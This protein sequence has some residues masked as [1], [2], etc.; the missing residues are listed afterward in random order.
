MSEEQQEEGSSRC[1]GRVEV[2][3]EG[4]WGTVCDD[5][6]D[7]KE[8]QVVCQQ[9]G[10]GA[11]V[12]T[13][14]EAYF[15]PGSGYILLDDVQCSG[16]EVSLGQCSHA[17][18]FVHNCGHE[19]DI[20]V[21]C[22]E[23]E[24]ILLENETSRDADWPQLQFTNGSGRCSGRVEVYYRGQWGR[25]CDDKWDLRE[26]DVVC[27]QLNCGRA[28]EAPVQSQFGD[29]PGEFLLDEMDCTG[30]ESFLGQCPHAGWHLHNCG[31]GEDASV[32]CEGHGE[33]PVA[34]PQ[35]D[36]NP[37]TIL[38]VPLHQFYLWLTQHLA[39]EEHKGPGSTSMS[40]DR[41]PD[42]APVIDPES[43][44]PSEKGG[45]VPVRLAGNHG[46][47]AGRVELFYQGVWGTVCDDLWD[48]PEANIICRQLGCGWA[49]SA[50]S[51]AYFGQGSGKILLDNVHCKGHEEHLEECSHLGWFSHNCDHS[52]DASVICS[53]AEYGTATLS[54]SP[55]AVMKGAME[56]EKSRCGGVITSAPGK[57]KNPPMNEM[58]D[59][60]TCVWE[61]RAST[62]ERI[63]LAFPSLDLDCTNEYFEIL[64]G[65]PSSMKSLGKP[66]RGLHVTFASHSSSMTLVYFRGENNI[67]KNFVAYYYF[68]AEEMT[69]KTPYLIIPLEAAEEEAI[70]TATSKMVTERPRNWPELQL[71]GGSNRCSGRVEILYQGVWG[72][73]CDDLWDLNEAEVVCRQ[74]GCGQAVSAL[75]KAYFGP[76]SG[77]IFLDNLQC[78]GVEHFLGQ[79]AHSGWSDH[80][81]GH[82]E[83][84]GVI[85]SDAEKPLSD[86]PG[87]WPEL[88]LVGGSSRCS[89]RVEILHQGVWGT[90]CDD[91]WGSNEAEVVCRQLECGQAV[92]SVGEAYFGPGSGDIFLDNLQ[93]S[94]MEHYLGQCPHSGWSEHNCG[95]HEDAGVIC[96]DSDAPPP[97]MPP[98]HQARVAVSFSWVL[99]WRAQDSFIY[100][101][102]AF[103]SAKSPPPTSQDPLTGGH[104]GGSNSCG[105]VISSLSGSFT[106]P[107]YPENYPTDIQCVWEIHVEKNFRIELMIPNLNLEDIL[108][109]PYDSIEIFDD[110][111]TVVFR[112]DYMTTN[113][114][115]YAFFNAISQDGRES[116]ERPVLRLAGSSG[117]C[118]GRVE[119]LHQGAWG[120]VCD[121]LWDLNEAEVVCRQLGCGHAIAAPGSAYFGPGSGNILLDNIQCSGKENHFGQCSSSAWLDHN[122][123]HHEDAGVICS[124]ADVT[125]SPTEGSHSCGG[126]ISSLSGSFSSPWYPTN[127]PTDTECIWKIHVAEKFNIELT[128]P[129]LKLVHA[130]SPTTWQ[131]VTDRFLCTEQ[132]DLHTEFQDR[133][134]YLERPFLKHKTEQKS[135]E[136]EDIYGCPYDF[137]EVFDGQQVASL[138]MGKVCAGTELTF[139]SSSNF[140]TVVFKSD[141]MITNSGFYALYNTVEQG[142]RQNGMALRLANGSHRCEGR[143]EISYNGTWGTVCDDSWDL[144]DAKVVCQQLGCG[145][146]M[147]APA[148]SYFDKGTGHIMLDDVQCMGDE[149]K[150]WQCTHH[151]W[152]SHN[153]G[154]HED[155][156]VVCSGIDDAPSGEPADEIFHCGGLL[157]NSSGSFSSPW[158][159]KKYPTNV[160]CAWDI[161][162]D[163]SAHI[164]LTFEVVKMENFYGCPY[165]FIEIFDGPRSEPFS[166]GRFCSETAPVFT[167]SSSHMSVVFHSDDIVTNIGFFASYK[168]LLQDEK[169]TDV[170]LRLANGSHPCEGRVE[171]YYNGSWGTVCD[172]SWDLRDAQVVC[173]QLGC[174]GAVVATGRAHFERGLGPIVLDDVECMGTEARLWQCLHSGW[175]AHNCGHHEDAG[176]VCSGGLGSEP[177]SLSQPAPS[178]PVSDMISASLVR[179]PEVHTSTGLDLRL[180]NGT[181]RCEGRVEVYYANTWGTVC[182]DN[183]SIEDAHVV[184]RQLGCGP[185]LSALAGSSFGPGSGSIALDDVNCTGKESSL[186]QCPHRDW[187]THNCGHKEDVGVICSDSAVNGHPATSVPE[188]H[189]HDLHPDLQLVRLADG[190]SQCEGRVEVYFN[191]TWGT[192]CDDLWG[193]QAAQVVCQQLGCGRALAAPRSSL[194]GDGSGPI[195]LDDVRCLGTET[196]LGCCHHLGLSVHNCGHH[197]DAGAIC[198]AVDQ[199]TIRLV[200]GKN[201][202]EGRVEV[203]HNG[204]WGTVCDDLWDIEDAHVVCRQL[205]CGRGVSALGSGHFGEGVGSIFLD[206]VKC[207]GSEMSLDQ[208]HHPGLSVHNCGHHEDASVICSASAAERP[209]SPVPTSNPAVVSVLATGISPTPVERTPLPDKGL[210]PPHCTGTSSAPTESSPPNDESSASTEEETSSDSSS[211]SEEEETSSGISSPPADTT[212]SHDESSGSTEDT[213]S[214]ISSASSEATSPNDVSSVSTE[215][216]ASDSSS[217]ST[218]E[219]SSPDV[220]HLQPLQKKRH[221]QIHLQPQQ[222]QVLKQIHL[223]PQQKTRAPLYQPLYL[224]QGL[225]GSL[226]DNQLGQE[227]EDGLLVNIQ[228][229]SSSSA[230][231]SSPNDISSTPAKSTS[232]SVEAPSS[233]GLSFATLG[234]T[235]S[236]CR[237]SDKNQQARG[238]EKRRNR[239]REGIGIKRSQS[240]SSNFDKS[241]FIACYLPLRLVG[242]R[243]RCEGRLEVR[244]EGEWGT[245]CDDRWNIKNARVVCR[246]LGCGLALG[247]PGRSHFGPGIGPILMNEVRCSGRED[248][249]ESCAHAGWTRHNCHHREDASVICAGPADSLVPKDNALRRWRQEENPEDLLARQSNHTSKLQPSYLALPHLFQAVIDRGYLR[250]LGYSSW[251]IHLNDKMCRPQVTGRYLIF[252]IPYGHCG[253][254]RQEHQGS[255]SYSNSIRGRMQGHPGSVIVRHKVPQVK[256]TCKV[257][258]QSAVEIVHGNDAKKDKASYDVTISFLQSPM[259]QNTAGRAPYASQ[260]EEVFLQATLHSHNPN[261]R[262]IVD[263]CVASPDASDFTT[264]K[265]DLI[266]EGCIKDSS[267]SNLHVPEKNV[268][269]FKF[270]AFSFLKSFD[271][272]YLQ[273]KVAVC[274]LGDHSSRCSQG[275]ASRGRRGVGSA[276]LREEQTEYFQTVGPLKIHR[277][278]NQ[279][280]ALV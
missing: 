272:V 226:G 264:V 257:D 39:V 123:G 166:L 266:Q 214:G 37:A 11:A 261:L 275:C 124:D 56:P 182:D 179:Q 30:T 168:S 33:E 244:H 198:S 240:H 254:I 255:L 40:A 188:E 224:N 53:D 151:G 196:N 145:K 75:G 232:P 129:S 8:A 61:I 85:C 207:Q 205:N 92:S 170:V 101:I 171:L 138:S 86:V 137:V 279:S 107:Q 140:M 130:F 144:T 195:F 70:P 87:D 72:T 77:D 62:S 157:T 3:F 160:V 210:C 50:L 155:A 112:S 169:D 259:S 209:A 218:E 52:E 216:S 97:P 28:L 141:T 22:S 73:V 90:I 277:E 110:I 57:I 162:V 10:C 246:L 15:G 147:S 120:T 51:E 241:D 269:Q 29:G 183:W 178:F 211:A 175:L 251:D 148:E 25:V 263:T 221:P 267:Y 262:L 256:F 230:E 100:I 249:L 197:E 76:G 111:L 276:E 109:C 21:I 99:V 65:P 227:L 245:V 131:T 2:Y 96:S 271:V 23:S 60:I 163:T 94:G 78:A 228:Y 186:A 127:Y 9:L 239:K 225:P 80:N 83:D 252:N 115:F 153:C 91:L 146:A 36:G 31:P 69:T 194:F 172:D 199:L 258:G 187:L 184:C 32:V 237:Q 191:G 164:R 116:E 93:C 6:W 156:S 66:C 260:R 17:G 181:S 59:N 235:L 79:C 18:W 217:A 253:T 139:L 16:T 173:R 233:L 193:I 4:V 247:A 174:G 150:V 122:C 19:E 47:C 84:A 206:D 223:Q 74:L 103:M 189:P 113:T 105:G 201:Q 58:H 71:V 215:D 117:Q 81:C 204:T 118:S 132:P 41:S 243:N 229:T 270:N 238:Q 212:S 102:S 220:I 280:K 88:R 273:C 159:P 142:E 149:A 46:S 200:D 213:S 104:Q 136:L 34:K 13:L 219:A 190:G 95:H 89:G 167:S 7:K 143:V 54:D 180:M 231:A 114:G 119:I 63:R 121:D 45:W 48:L 35:G 242:G 265:Y 64:D 108:G 42:T 43:Y 165:D 185:A 161:Q 24:H 133:Q 82:H 128:I 208:C 55:L 14:G 250:R 274:H 5:L 176:V 68:E 234:E 44:K 177:A 126:V 202:C 192:V 26:A 106:S 38:S 125:P 49:V 135:V 203:Q 236:E 27:R 268:A 222:N 98:E 278:A 152:F 20:G 248:S 134:G 158:Y 67:G 1:S 12:S 154:H